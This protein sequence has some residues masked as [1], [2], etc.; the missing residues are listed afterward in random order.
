MDPAPAGGR[1]PQSAPSSQPA[2][3]LRTAWT[4]A[5]PL[6][7]KIIIGAAGLVVLSLLLGWLG[8]RREAASARRANAE[9]RA[10]MAEVR[11]KQTQLEELAAAIVATSSTAKIVGYKVLRQVETVFSDGEKSSAAAVMLLKALAARK[12][13]NAIINLDTRQTPSGKWVARG[14]AVCIEEAG[15]LGGPPE[16]SR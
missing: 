3:D 1:T 7:Q 6:V 8:R 2:L 5:D 16:T 15:R 4:N 9:L 13:A 11:L 14:D 10:G 12:G